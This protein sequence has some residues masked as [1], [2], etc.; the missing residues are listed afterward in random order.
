MILVQESPSSNHGI[1]V[2]KWVSLRGYYNARRLNS[3]NDLASR[4][5][6]DAN[7]NSRYSKGTTSSISDS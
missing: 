7:S 6:S 2:G 1:Q 5:I 4:Y 3:S